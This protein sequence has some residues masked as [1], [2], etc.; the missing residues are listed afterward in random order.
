TAADY[1]LH[2]AFLGKSSK[3]GYFP[4]TKHYDIDVL[5][6]QK[7][8]TRILWCGRF[9]DW[10]HPEQAIAVAARL[11][12]AGYAF[13]LELIGSGALE[14][15]LRQQIADGGLSDCVRLTGALSPDEVR[16]RMETA[17]IYLFTS[18]FHEGWGAVLNEA[19]NSGC[20]VAA[21]HAIG[22]VP[23]LVKPGE[24]GQIY[25]SGDTDALYRK[26]K[27]LLDHP[28]TQ[29]MLGRNAYD[30]IVRLW[31]AETAAER[32]LRLTEELR[33]HGRCDLYTDGPCS[34]APFLKNNWFKE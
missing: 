20:A 13:E 23:F 28:E 4:E 26:V 15:T 6:A 3:W 32:L 16:T 18:D 14:Q 11:K 10:K 34:R 24:N 12:A 17:G 19:M 9:L 31:N 33:K 8:P 22:A 27:F 7:R 2:G 25:R 29:Q 5:M 1:N 30:T 21:S